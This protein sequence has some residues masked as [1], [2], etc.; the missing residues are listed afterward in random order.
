MS[1]FVSELVYLSYFFLQGWVT[2]QQW[3][4]E[5]GVLLQ[6]GEKGCGGGGGGG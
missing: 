1:L 6:T 5:M 4:K 2:E 3:W